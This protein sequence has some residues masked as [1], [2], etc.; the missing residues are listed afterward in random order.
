MNLNF[1]LNQRERLAVGVAGVVVALF[2]MVQYLI[3][4]VFEK[5][6]EL[7]GRL[8]SKKA[9]IKDMA[10]MRMEYL[11]MKDRAASSRMRLTNRPP[12]FTLFSF[13]D[14]LAG[15]TGLKDRIDYMKPSS[16][17]REDSG[18][19]ISRVEMKLQ[20]ITLKD[21]TAYIFKVETSP[22]MLIIKR[23]SITRTGRETGL[24]SAV[25]QVETFES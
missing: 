8:A 23:L 2:V 16:A 12:G 22:N 17:V 19:K 25:L 18:M 10:A 5:R 7:A 15:E 13:M 9:V 20:E 14:Q 21:L 6:D 3:A 4:P 24:I 11:S 1:N